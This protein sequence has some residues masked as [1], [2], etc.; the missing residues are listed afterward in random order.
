MRRFAAIVHAL[1]LT[2]T[3]TQ[4][5]QQRSGLDA[6][7]E[8]ALA[9]GATGLR[10]LP[11]VLVAGAQLIVWRLRDGIVT[12]TPA[13]VLT[14]LVAAS[15]LGFVFGDYDDGIP[16]LIHA[17]IVCG[18]AALGLALLRNNW[19]RPQGRFLAYASL[20]A[21]SACIVAAPL[22][23]IELTTDWIHR[24]GLATLGAGALL[25][26]CYAFDTTRTWAFRSAIVVMALGFFVSGL[27]NWHQSK[28]SFTA[29]YTLASGAQALSLV[30]SV[31]AWLRLNQIPPP[32]AGANADL[33]GRV[34]GAGAWR[35][36]SEDFYERRL[37]ERRWQPVLS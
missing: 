24:G 10:L 21:G 15:G 18:S 8:E 14:L 34:D 22:I 31:W 20:A 12:L 5:R 30:A 16:R 28:A 7:I 29:T 13:G 3:P 33:L 23:R 35:I 6:Y 11:Q 2:G 32:T 4:L 9:H 37:R 1:A 19:G 25:L 36:E 27:G 26:S 17:W